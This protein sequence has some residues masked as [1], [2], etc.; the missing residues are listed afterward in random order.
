[1]WSELNSAR[2]DISVQQQQQ[3][4]QGLA[5]V[6]SWAALFSSCPVRNQTKN[7]TKLMLPRVL[8]SKLDFPSRYTPLL[9]LTYFPVY[10]RNPDE[11]PM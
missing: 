3:Q 1:M 2:R 11:R 5:I 6:R 4:Q 10:A 7:G 9:N 8:P